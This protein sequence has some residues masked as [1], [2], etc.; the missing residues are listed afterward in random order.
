MTI[1]VTAELTTIDPLRVVQE[2]DVMALA[3]ISGTL[4]RQSGGK[5]S[6][7]LAERCE[8]S[9]SGVQVRCQLR[10]GLKFSDGS[11]LDANDVVA[12]FQRAMN[13]PANVN[14]GLVAPLRAVEAANPREVTFS[15]KRRTPSFMLALTEGAL[16]VFP[17]DRLDKP[18]FFTTPVSS[19]PYA[20]TK[21]RGGE[22]TF[23]RNA[24]YPTELQPVVRTVKFD[25]VVDTSTRLSQLNTGQLDLAYALPANLAAQVKSPGK[26]YATQ[27]YGGIYLYVNNSSGPL[28]D[29][30]VRKAMSA[31]ID[32]DEINKIAFLGKNKPLGGFLPSV[33]EGHDGEASVARNLD[34]AKELLQ[35]TACE[36]GCKLTAMQRAGYAPYDAITTVIQKNLADIGIDVAINTVDQATANTNEQNGNFQVEVGNLYDVVNSPELVMLNYGLSSAGG[37]RALFSDYR[38]DK[39]DELVRQV[40]AEDDPQKRAEILDEINR[41][42]AEELPFIPLVDHATVW[43]SRVSPRLVAFT[44]SGTFQVGTETKGPGE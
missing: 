44:A 4:L 43:G 40:A 38:S 2:V 23:V 28:G 17:A 7:G 20:L 37:I 8:A 41:L 34:A 15:L 1:G 33:M 13:D 32:R 27:Q 39:M 14:G 31:A 35:G 5:P 26:A 18:G 9:P 6:P 24:N 21:N 19:G 29:P 11:P 3:M 30:R 42:F 36:N 16:G 12:T 22:M 25:A 10:D